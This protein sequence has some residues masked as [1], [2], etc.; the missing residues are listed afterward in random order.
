MNAVP[1]GKIA[2]HG[3]MKLDKSYSFFKF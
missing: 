3:Y 1:E 2:M